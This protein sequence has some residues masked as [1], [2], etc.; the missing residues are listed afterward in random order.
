MVTDG[1]SDVGCVLRTDLTQEPISKPRFQ[2]VS[3]CPILWYRW[4]RIRSDEEE[5]FDLLPNQDKEY[6]D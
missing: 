3:H 4:Q 5:E 1:R 2:V 6:N